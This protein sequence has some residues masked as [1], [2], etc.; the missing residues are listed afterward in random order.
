MP[1]ITKKQA[2]A[3][4]DGMQ[5]GSCTGDCRTVWLRNI[6]YAL[7]TDTNPL[8]LTAAER[9]RMTAKVAEVKS[10]KKSVTKKVNK[11][12]LTRDSPPYPANQFCGKTMKGNDGKLYESMPN[13]NGVCSWKLSQD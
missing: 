3:L 1:F 5:T 8:K 9:K 4:L 7:K 11:K 10:K 12:Y 13:K 6:Q 2:F